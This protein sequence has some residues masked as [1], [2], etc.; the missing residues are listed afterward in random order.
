MQGYHL[1]GIKGGAIGVA[2]L[3][4]AAWR[5]GP[6]RAPSPCC[7]TGCHPEASLPGGSLQ[8][9]TQERSNSGEKREVM[10]QF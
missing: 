4:L 5:L 3:S 2:S 7:L 10:E 9:V 1:A 8:D 6:P